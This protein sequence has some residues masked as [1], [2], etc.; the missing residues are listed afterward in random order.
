[1][2]AVRDVERE[3]LLNFMSSCFVATGQDEFY[4]QADA[5]T[6]SLD[7]LHH[8]TVA[9]YRPFYTRM[10]ATSINDFNKGLIIANLLARPQFTASE[11][12]I[13][14]R[15]IAR[16]LDAMPPPQAY[17]A[18]YRLIQRRVNNRRTRAIMRDYLT[19]RPDPQFH[20][21]KYRRFVRAIAEH[22]HL[23]L[24]AESQ[25]ILF[26]GHRRWNR[27]DTPVFES[28]RRAHYEARA[29]LDL[30]LSVAEGLAE[31]LGYSRERLLTQF[32]DTMTVRE[33]QRLQRSAQRSGLDFSDA[34]MT[35]S[36]TRLA[37]YVAGLS[38][39]E[40]DGAREKTPLAFQSA[41]KRAARRTAQRYG[42]VGLVLD[43]SRSARSSVAKANRPLAIA[44]GTVALMREIADDVTVHWTPA[45]VGEPWD[46][47]AA[48]PTDL[49][50]PLL[51]ALAT[52][53]DHV[54]IV[55]DG[56]E[57]APSGGAAEVVRIWRE[58]LSGH[59]K[60]TLTHINPVFNPQTYAVR[61]LSPHI[62]AFG[63]RNVDDV[64][65]AMLMARFKA[66]VFDLRQLLQFLD[67]Q[68]R[69]A[70]AD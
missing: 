47:V 7:F 29:I 11:K 33:K 46:A 5:H 31:R 57:N 18:L 34:M 15:L 51:N 55:S 22:A 62:P 13:E 60:T 14:G 50:T 48:G 70:L 1:M 53:P 8:Y 9:N 23:K 4:S 54:V 41:A 17:R 2:N 30:P 56:F 3:D 40:R 67:V 21:L 39:A 27:F 28:Y 42:R 45:Y 64:P 58:K 49:A 38:D 19:S 10:L 32:K 16:A 43:R 69:S 6:V 68:A 52:E 59:R 26:R 63:V 65:L 66:G 24:D 35:M 25:Q 37:S 12:A 20:T 44:V 61:S 36:L